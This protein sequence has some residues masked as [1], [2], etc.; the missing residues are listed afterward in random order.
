M[1]EMLANINDL[2]LLCPFLSLFSFMCGGA[3]RSWAVLWAV[4]AALLALASPSLALGT[5]LAPPSHA[6]AT[7][8]GKT[9]IY[10]YIRNIPK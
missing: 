7:F 2:F 1:R 5:F 9:T 6:N 10:N 3:R 8:E 4:C